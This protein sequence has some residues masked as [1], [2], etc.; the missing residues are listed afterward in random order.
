[1]QSATGIGSIPP[2]PAPAR[3]GKSEKEEV[4][5]S[6]QGLQRL[7]VERLWELLIRHQPSLE[8]AEVV[9]AVVQVVGHGPIHSQ[10]D[11][12]QQGW[13]SG[14]PPLQLDYMELFRGL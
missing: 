2:A 11:M 13:L 10:R 12:P 9:G 14:K 4:A 8:E 1:M 7:T 6:V 5:R 3:W